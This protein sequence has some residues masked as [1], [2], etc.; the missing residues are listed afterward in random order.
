[1][2]GKLGSQKHEPLPSEASVL[3]LAGT[4]APAQCPA[5]DS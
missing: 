4:A 2:E 3:Q 5:K 1:M